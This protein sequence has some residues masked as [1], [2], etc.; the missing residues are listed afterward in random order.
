MVE[1]NSADKKLPIEPSEETHNFVQIKDLPER[2]KYLGACFCLVGAKSKSPSVSGKGWQKPDKLMSINDPR[3][4]EHLQRGGNYGVVGGYG[5]VILDADTPELQQ[6]IEEKLPPTFTVLSP[7]SKGNH[8][9]YRCSLERP[10]R[11]RDKNKINVGDVQGLGKMVVG[12]CSIHPNGGVY[13]VI[14]DIDFAPITRADIVEA[15]EEYIIPEQEIINAENRAKEEYDKTNIDISI[16][17]VVPMAGLRQTGDEYVGAHPVHGSEGGMNFW[18]NPAK[19]VFHCFRCESGGGPLLWIA[20]EEGIIECAEAIAGALKGDKFKEVLKVAVERGLIKEP[21]IEIN[22][23][24]TDTEQKRL[25]FMIRKEKKKMI[26]DLF[27]AINNDTQ[28]IAFKDNK[29]VYNY[30]GGVYQDNG[31]TVIEELVEIL[32]QESSNI[33]IINEVINKVRIANYIDRDSISISPN[34]LCVQNGLIDVLTGELKPHTHEEIFFSKLPINYNPEATC[35]AINKFLSE[36]L[37]EGNIAVMEEYIGYCL[38]RKFTHHKI[39]ILIGDGAN[40]KTT[41]INLLINFLGKNNIV[42]IPLQ[43]L[44]RRFKKIELF[45][46]LANIYDDLTD[47]GL[48]E[49]GSLKMFYGDSPITAEVK[50]KQKNVTFWNYA[51][52]IFATNKPPEIIHDDSDAFWR[53][54]ITITFPNQFLG[55]Q[56]D[57]N[58]IETLTTPEELSGLLNLALTGLKR[59]LSNGVFSY[60]PSIDD[61][62]HDYIRKSD[63]VG[64]FLLD[65]IEVGGNEP[66]PKAVLYPIYCEYCLKYKLPSIGKETFGKKLLQK[67]GLSI[68]QSRLKIEGK[69]TTCWTN[70]KLKSTDEETEEKQPGQAKIDE[71]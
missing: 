24:A 9:Y 58:L 34:L 47:R 38:L 56:A 40:G 57:K 26:Q 55:T 7:G 59:L 3:L 13:K 43:D 61:I 19:N 18:V 68:G 25:N 52:G 67:L 5:I 62:K 15:L 45:G 32:I 49:S 35:P 11:L 33:S 28:F 42:G 21:T 53:R 6:L 12:P 30:N 31:A 23:D 1:T 48:Q 44:G 17:Q 20:I 63:S 54:L 41:F 71:E 2:F 29:Q 60:N 16:T 22:K 50:H 70:I 51:K 69:Q 4:Q 36:V 37:H 65:C 27:K 8:C 14:K 66:I 10:I 39:L 46:K 64:A